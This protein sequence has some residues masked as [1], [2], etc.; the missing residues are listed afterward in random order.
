[1]SI[2]NLGIALG[3]VLCSAIVICLT[4]DIYNIIKGKV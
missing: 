4:R 3:V 2:A 1:M